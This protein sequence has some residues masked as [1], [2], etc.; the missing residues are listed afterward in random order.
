MQIWEFIIFILCWIPIEY[1]CIH[2]EVKHNK[3]LFYDL[4]RAEIIR[5]LN[6]FEKSDVK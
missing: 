4:H 6:K 2:L 1:L 3:E 5:I